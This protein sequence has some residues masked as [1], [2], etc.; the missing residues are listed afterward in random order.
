MLDSPIEEIKSKI[1]IAELLGEYIQ[2]KPAGSNYKALCPFHREKTPSFMVSGER[3]IWKCFGCGEGGDIFAFVM[4]MEG[5]EFPEA[6]RLLAGKAGVVLKQQNPQVS[7]QKNKLLEILDLATKYYHRVLLDSSQAKQAKDYLIKERSLDEETLENFYLG[8]A[9]ESWDSIINFLKKKGYSEEEIFLAG[10]SVKKEKGVGYYDRFRGRIMFPIHDIHGQ[11][12]GFTG[13]IL[14]AKDET[15]KYVNTPQTLVYDKSNVLY[16]LDKAKIEIKKQK[17]VILVEG[18]MDVVALHQAGIKNV[19]A[20]SGT[21]LTS[22]QIQILKRYS[23]NIIIAFDADVAGQ[24]AAFRGI[25]L[26]LTQGLNIKII[27]L[28]KD[29]QG[30]PLYKDPDECVKKDKQ[31]FLKALK[32]AHSI[33]DYYFSTVLGQADLAKVEEKKRVAKTLTEIIAKVFD[34]VEK[35]HYLK[36]LAQS[37]DTPEEI[38]RKMVANI[39]QKKTTNKPEEESASPVETKERSVILAERLLGFMIKYPYL[40]QDIFD[41]LPLEI[42]QDKDL[43]YLYKELIIYYTKTIGRAQGSSPTLDYKDFK[44]G[45]ALEKKE[46]LDQLMLSVEKDFDPEELN[47]DVVRKEIVQAIKTLKVDFI[48]KSLKEITQSMKGAEERKDEAEVKKLAEEFNL[49]TEEL[50]SLNHS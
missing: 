33:L 30:K 23:P 13:R 21:S 42:I 10:L 26:A 48:N 8:F 31:A 7:S 14:D 36:K 50:Q 15:A 12:V 20:V 24:G 6:L 19:V 18:N 44:E 40:V 35:A 34:P 27:E 32:E 47:E 46:K 1:D 4:K 41:K 17:Y 9:I 29:E 43:A 25:E 37:L 16:G 45:L 5:L 28:P 2:L 49:L 38:L 39:S 11:P 3:Q 22:G